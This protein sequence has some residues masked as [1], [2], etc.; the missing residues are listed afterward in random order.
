MLKKREVPIPPKNKKQTLEEVS[1]FGKWHGTAKRGS[2][3]VLKILSSV[4]RFI[5]G[6]H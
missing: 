3:F 5:K 6:N 4:N 1:I 2:N